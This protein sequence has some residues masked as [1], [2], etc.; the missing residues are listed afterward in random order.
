M[1]KTNPYSQLQEELRKAWD[2]LDYAHLWLTAS[3]W[4]ENTSMD[5][6]LNSAQQKARRY[7][8]LVDRISWTMR[9]G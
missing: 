1:D 2:E 6:K 5:D 3:E 7:L 4:D 8:E 9:K